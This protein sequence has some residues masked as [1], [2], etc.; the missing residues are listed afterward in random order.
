VLVTLVAAAAPPA[1][2][3]VLVGS[4]LAAAQKLACER[5]RVG[6]PRHVVL[7]FLDLGILFAPGEPAGRLPA[8][9]L[10]FALCGLWAA[11]VVIAPAAWHSRGGRR[12]SPGDPPVEAD[13]QLL[14]PALRCL[15]GVAASGYAA[16]LLGVGRPYWAM[17]TA[18]AVFVGTRV[19][20]GQRALQRTVGTLLGLGVFAVLDQF[21]KD[22]DLVLVTL[23]VATGVI[24]EVFMTAN[25]WLGT[26]WVTPMALLIT[27]LPGD[28]TADTLIGERLADTLVGSLLGIALTGITDARPHPHHHDPG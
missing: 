20:H 18:A 13:P 8:R 27:S 9:W 28:A 4:A 15:V 22:S 19:Q 14:R 11:A 5:Y 24:I 26:V 7:A 17:V 1:A 12:W 23:V 25:Y 6:P 10:T 3:L 21:A 16:L 2:V